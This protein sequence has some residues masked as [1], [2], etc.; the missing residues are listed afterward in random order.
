VGWIGVKFSP[1]DQF[2]AT[3]NSYASY[4]WDLTRNALIG[5]L[6]NFYLNISADWAL[7]CNAQGVLDFGN[8]RE[9]RAL[10][11]RL[12]DEVRTNVNWLAFSRDSRL[13]AVQT[14]DGTVHFWECATGNFLPVRLSVPGRRV[15]MAFS[16]DGR[17]LA[18]HENNPARRNSLFD[19]AISLWE[20]ASG[21]R[22]AG[23]VKA[24]GLLRDWHFDPG[25]RY[26][27]ASLSIDKWSTLVWRLPVLPK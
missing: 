18:T 13:V 6:R 19:G 10:A 1:D 24:Y 8:P 16:P 3:R 22:I 5:D 12:P 2:L 21:R 26:V 4:A 25:S 23:P 14:T 11:N 15:S 17:Y 27:A 7:A 9:P 20:V